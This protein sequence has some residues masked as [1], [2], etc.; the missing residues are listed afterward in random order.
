MVPLI[1]CPFAFKAI[2]KLD[3]FAGFTIGLCAS[4]VT[5]AIIIAAIIIGFIV[6]A[7]S[8]EEAINSGNADDIVEHF[9][10]GF[11]ILFFFIILVTYLAIFFV[12]YCYTKRFVDAQ[13]P[14]KAIFMFISGYI[15]C[16]IAIYLI[17][18]IISLATS[19]V[20]GSSALSAFYILFQ[21][22]ILFSI[23]KLAGISLMF[24]IKHRNSFMLALWCAF[25]VYF[26]PFLFIFIGICAKSL[27]TIEYPFFFFDI[28][29]ISL[30]SYFYYKYADSSKDGNLVSNT[31][32]TAQ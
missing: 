16:Y 12:L 30:G 7:A 27:P 21:F 11:L 2:F 4:F 15:I 29:S 28:A 14:S 1:A 25:G 26:G 8:S 19:D 13:H 3:S 10:F 23:I 22:L 24:M 5:A 17:I 20:S 18:F 31:A 9:G 6:L 32:Y